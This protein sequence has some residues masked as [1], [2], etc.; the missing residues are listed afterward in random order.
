MRV[1][2]LVGI[3]ERRQRQLVRV[4]EL[5]LVGLLFVGIERRALGV[6]VTTTVALAVTKLPALLERD[7]QLELDAGLTLWLTA[8][9]FLHALGVVGVPG[10]ETSLYAGMPFWDHLTHALSS[11]VVAG[12]GYATVRTIEEHSDGVRLDRR[13][14]FA[15]ILL[16]VMAFGVLW[17]LLEFAIGLATAALGFETAGFTQH[18]LSDTMLDLVFDGLGGVLVAVWGHAHLTNVVDDLQARLGERA[19]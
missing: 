19:G 9:V 11:S 15:F 3:D 13:F 7:Y 16:F 8:A 12:A 6:V 2:D 4:M 17:E 10:T 14:T 1:R 18:G 5:A